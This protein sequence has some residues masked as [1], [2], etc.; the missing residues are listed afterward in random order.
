M[1]NEDTL[2]AKSTISRERYLRIVHAALLAGNYRFARESVLKWLATYPGDMLAGL[3]YAQAL[4]GENRT[5]QALLILEGLCLA[6]PEFE[7][8]A[9][10]LVKALDTI[11]DTPLPIN[12]TARREAPDQGK[13]PRLIT[14]IET[15]RAYWFALT[16]ISH[17]HL[18][19]TALSSCMSFELSFPIGDEFRKGCHSSILVV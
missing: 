17:E 3:Y 2:S 1:N 19:L 13:N 7:A 16:G 18:Y 12:S 6:D 4:F 9:K 5:S 15:T 14:S 11:P 10:L 8:A